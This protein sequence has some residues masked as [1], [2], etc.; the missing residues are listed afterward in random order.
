MRVRQ[1]ILFLIRLRFDYDQIARIVANRPNPV[2]DQYCALFKGWGKC[3][4]STVNIILKLVAPF[5]HLNKKGA[6]PA[7]RRKWRATQSI[8]AGGL[9]AARV[10]QYTSERSLL[11]CARRLISWLRRSCEF[12][13]IDGPID[14][15]FTH[16]H[17]F[18]HLSVER[19]RDPER[20]QRSINRTPVRKPY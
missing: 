16:P 13:R 10:N 15:K 20:E 17:F 6:L 14:F 19:S 3:F 4:Y 11:K 18:D 12:F 5:N 8:S 9:S 7:A 2:F 1:L